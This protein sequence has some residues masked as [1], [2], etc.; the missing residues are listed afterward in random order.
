MR[1]SKPLIYNS[2][3]LIILV[4]LNMSKLSKFTFE[5]SSMIQPNKGVIHTPKEFIRPLDATILEYPEWYLV[6]SSEEFATY[7]TNHF[8]SEFPFF[9]EIWQYW[10]AYYKAN[11][12]IQALKTRNWDDQVMLMVIGSS[13]TA[14]YFL[15]GLYEISFGNVSAKISGRVAEDDYAAKVVAE[16]VEFIKREPWYEFDFMHS[17]KNLWTE[18]TFFGKGFFRKLERKYILSSEYLIKAS[19]GKLIGLAS[20]AA[21][22]VA[23]VKTAVLI[24]NLPPAFTYSREDVSILNN[25]NKGNALL[26]VPRLAQFTEYANLLASQNIQFQEI[27][28]NNAFITLSILVG[29][30][31]QKECDASAILYKQAILTSPGM[32][33]VMLAVP[34]EQL[35]SMLLGLKKSHQLIEHIYDY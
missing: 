15:R 31:W 24:T 19:Y 3:I 5:Q 32:T 7:T 12:L 23:E 6:Y 35:G 4:L 18:N 25:D 29:P 14:E 20:H 1:L 8:P 34:V 10:D 26:L 22:G 28:G 33:R 30:N 17:L 16:Y 27:A 2:F 21:F 13:T 9:A 11:H